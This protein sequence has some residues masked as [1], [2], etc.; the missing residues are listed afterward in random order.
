VDGLDQMASE[1]SLGEIGGY[2]DNML[3]GLVKERKIINL[4]L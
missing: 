1:C 3:K 4:S 2:A